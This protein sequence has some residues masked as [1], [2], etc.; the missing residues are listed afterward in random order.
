M[1]KTHTHTHTHTDVCTKINSKK[2]G[3]YQPL[4]SVPN[5]TSKAV[6]IHY[7]TEN[8]ISGEVIHPL[9][10]LELSP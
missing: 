10:G 8:T 3:M 7:E 2:L 9:I 4:A 6:T 5:L 1:Q